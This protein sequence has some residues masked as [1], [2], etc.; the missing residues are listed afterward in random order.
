MRTAAKFKMIP[1]FFQFQIAEAR[2]R[3]DGGL[4]A[5]ALLLLSLFHP[6]ATAWLATKRNLRIGG[7]ILRNTCNPATGCAGPCSC[8]QPPLLSF[9]RPRVFSSGS[10]CQAGRGAQACTLCLMFD[11]GPLSS[12]CL[13]TFSP[14]TL[15]IIAPLSLGTMRVL[16]SMRTALCH[17][18]KRMLRGLLRWCLQTVSSPSP[19]SG[20]V[21]LVVFCSSTGLL[22]WLLW[23]GW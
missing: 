5:S 21:S 3:G 6:E 16:E 23:P 9:A 4:L 13:C 18:L 20:L 1:K 19:L 12:G 8:S 2:F 10:C 11:L 15:E 7:P 17:A 22:S 14:W